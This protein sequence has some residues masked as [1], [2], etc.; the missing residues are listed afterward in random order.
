MAMTVEQLEQEAVR[1]S[2]DERME[3][4]S[5][6]SDGIGT[7]M[8]PEIERAWEEELKRRIEE[9]DSGKATTCNVD[10]VLAELRAN[11]PD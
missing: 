7:G 6:I 4:I 2:E 8:S 1:L 9:L 10:A 5:R 3:L 11:A